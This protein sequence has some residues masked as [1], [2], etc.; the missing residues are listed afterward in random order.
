MRQTASGA[1]EQ[2]IEY[3]GLELRV[4]VSIADTNAD[5]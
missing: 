1:V 3:V 2:A 5:V 4:G